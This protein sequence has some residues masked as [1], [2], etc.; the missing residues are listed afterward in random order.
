MNLIPK[1]KCWYSK[2]KWRNFI[3]SYGVTESEPHLYLSVLPTAGLFN[4]EPPDMQLLLKPLSNV[5]VFSRLFRNVK[6]CRIKRRSQG[7]TESCTLIRHRWIK[8]GCVLNPL[9]VMQFSSSAQKVNTDC[10]TN[11]A[12]IQL[13]S[14]KRR[15]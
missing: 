15:S 1:H 5:A 9:C 4:C 13:I 8:T 10:S 12:Q 3:K 7:Y 2:R 14:L 6:I 11:S